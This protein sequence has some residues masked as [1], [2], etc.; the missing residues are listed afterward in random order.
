MRRSLVSFLTVVLAVIS[1]G[2]VAAQPMLDSP[3]LGGVAVFGTARTRAN[4]WDWF[5]NAPEGDYS[6]PAVLIRVG[7]T[8]VT[9]SFDW[10]VDFALPILVN[11]PIDA[12]MPA[13]QGQ[14]GLG[15]TYSASNGNVAHAAMLFP[16][17]FLVRFKN[18][19]GVAGQDL[20]IGRMEFND[21]GEVVP[22]DASLAALK[23]ERISQRL[24]GTFGFSDVGRSIDG[25][26]YSLT[27]GRTNVT[28]IGGR[29]T[30][31][32]FQVDGW[33]ELNINLLYGAVT[34]QTGS[35]RASGELRIFGLAYDDY[36]HGVVKTDNRT[37][38]ARAADGESIVVG[39]FGAH[40]LQSVGTSGGPV[41][42][43]L[44]G[45]GQAG[46]WGTLADRSAAVA[47]EAGWQPAALT[48]MHLWIR[49]G[50]DYAAGDHD[51]ADQVHHTFFPVLP[52]PRI[53]A[54]FP[55]YTMMNTVDV[56]GE[57]IARPL[58]R[59]TLRGDVHG[60][61]LA[62]THDLWYTGGGA[63]QPQTFGYTGRPSSGQSGLS[64]V[65]DLSCDFAFSPH[66]ALTAY[67][68]YANGGPVTGAIYSGTSGAAF[69]YAELLLRF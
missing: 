26:Q 49:G 33:G 35:Q 63:F 20:A 57:L 38:T 44:W 12:V 8:Q 65:S 5:G 43:L 32:V 23:R 39:T 47:I 22:K 14:L 18:L 19:G 36:R 13:P 45:A 9:T 7:L 42:V 48:S 29:P 34:R 60:V 66:V 15:A 16:K 58:S 25:A 37:A 64:T 46:S 40:Y 24:L 28:V 67:G 56:F 61:R 50:Y 53:Y 3:T 17:Q 31:G 59:L 52:T 68:G 51:A 54:R 11:L 62:S 2:G 10:Q 55:F 4:W 30:Q 6:Y 69:G 1:D 21:G 41:D 27:K